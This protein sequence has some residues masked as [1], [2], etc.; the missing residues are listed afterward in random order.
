MSRALAALLAGIVFLTGCENGL[1]NK[2]KVQQAII[3]RLKTKSGLDINSLDITTTSVS[4]NRNMAYATVAFHPKADP[5]VNSGMT[6]KYTLEDREGK[7]V[8][9]DVAD[10]QGRG[11]GGHSTAS[12]DQLPPGHPSLSSGEQLPPGHPSLDGSKVPQAEAATGGQGANG[13]KQ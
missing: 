9:V 7:W 2:E 3:E 5:S 12:G 13:R 11:M 8:V 1:K 4:F 10:S 6:M